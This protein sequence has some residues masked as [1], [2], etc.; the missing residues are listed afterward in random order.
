MG[1]DEA[2]KENRA[3]E[4]RREGRALADRL[5]EALPEG[6]SEDVLFV[7]FAQLVGRGAVGINDPLRFIDAVS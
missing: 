4:V 2:A 3:Q 1:H 5:F 7:A 6:T